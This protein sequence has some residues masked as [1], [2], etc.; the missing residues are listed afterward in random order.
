[1]PISLPFDE[2]YRYKDDFDETYRYKDDDDGIII[3]VSLT[4]GRAIAN[5]FA[6]VDTG[7]AVCLFSRET[8]ERIGVLPVRIACCALL[9]VPDL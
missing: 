4:D 1:M 9:T 6:A 3:P 8:G 2:T 7:A 5:T